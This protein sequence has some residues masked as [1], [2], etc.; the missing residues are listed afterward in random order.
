MDG[1]FEVAGEVM[2]ARLAKV[3][4]KS[5][6]STTKS[7]EQYSITECMEALESLRDING[8]TFNKF[9]DKIVPCIEWRKA[10]LAMTEERKRFGAERPSR[11]NMDTKRLVICNSCNICNIEA[12]T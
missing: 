11:M 7:D 12:T 3:K 10:F 5:A 9:M 1:Y 6:E 4:S 8:D 2:R